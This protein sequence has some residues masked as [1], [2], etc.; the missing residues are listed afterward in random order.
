MTH[1]AAGEVPICCA[2]QRDDDDKHDGLDEPTM[3]PT[4]VLRPTE[5]DLPGGG[6]AV[7]AE[8]DF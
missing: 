5:I 2:W 4:M 7:T 1:G 6:T 8:D 3:H